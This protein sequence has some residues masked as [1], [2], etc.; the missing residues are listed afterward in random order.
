MNKLR[1]FDLSYFIGKSHFEKDGTQNYLIFQP[2]V[3][4][5]IVNAITS[6]QIMKMVNVEKGWQIIDECTE[7]IEEIIT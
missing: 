7:T 4:Y 2:I 6:I 5:F 1:T 3:R